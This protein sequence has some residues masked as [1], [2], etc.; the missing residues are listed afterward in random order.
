MFGLTRKPL[1]HYIGLSFPAALLLGLWTSINHNRGEEQS[2][3]I[4]VV[5]TG[6]VGGYFGV[7]LVRAGLD[8]HFLARGKHLRS[9][10]ENGL[11]VLSDEWTLRVMVHATAE[12]EEIGPVDLVLFCVKSFDTVE[13]SRLL[14]PMVE[15][16]TVILNLQNGIDNLDK[17]AELYGEDRVLGGISYIEAAVASPGVIAHMGAP[18]RIVFGEMSGKRTQR[19]LRVLD[20]FR[21]AD[22]EASL[23][24]NIVEMLWSRFLF[25]C[26]VHGVSSLVHARLGMVLAHSETREL[27]V[28]VMREVEAVARRKGVALPANVV[29]ESMALAESCDPRFKCSMLRDLEW[30][31]QT[32]VDTLNGMVVKMGREVGVETPLNQAIYASL[33]LENYKL[34][35]PIWA[36]RFDEIA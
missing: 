31:R 8:T 1:W 35:N 32:E 10:L 14:A 2:M 19:A 13:A 3:K 25:I 12:P 16:D 15:E 22:I 33:S 23:S 30:K 26:A 20:T 18:G 17:L 24:E 21:A 36:G 28:G 4:G 29:E 7:L 9:I 27:L 11:E 6:G 34:L 5:G